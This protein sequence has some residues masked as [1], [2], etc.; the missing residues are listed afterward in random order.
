MILALDLGT[1]TG[2]CL[3]HAGRV[4]ASGVM[5]LKPNRYDSAGMRF[6]KFRTTMNKLF[7]AYPA[8]ERIAFEEVRN[9][10]GTDAAHIYGGLL[11]TMQTFALDKSVQYEGHTVQA[12]KKFATGKGNAGKEAVTAEV[13]SWGYFPNDDN[14]ADAIALCR[15]VMAEA[16]LD[17]AQ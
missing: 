6:I 12:I 1:K 11:A 7:E 8:I 2:W 3:G 13:R 4:V 14:E 16:V 15:L 5:D 10:K 17:G 9:H